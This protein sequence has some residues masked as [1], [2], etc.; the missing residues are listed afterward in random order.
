MPVTVLHILGGALAEHEP[1]Q[2]PVDD[3]DAVEITRAQDQV[4]LFGRLEKHGDVVRV[5]GQVA[6]Q[7]EHELVA[8]LQ[9]PL[10]ARDI[11]AAQSAFLL[12]M[13]HVDR[14]VA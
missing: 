3:A 8:V 10:E 14:G 5:V 7:F 9:G 6:V 12:P 11:G 13:E 4:G 2:G 1:A